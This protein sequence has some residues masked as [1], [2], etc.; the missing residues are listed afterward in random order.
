MELGEP[1]AVGLLDDHDRR[2]RNVDADLD[3][4]RGDQHVELAR[5]EARHH[6]APLGRTHAA[7]HA[8]DPEVAQLGAPQALGLGLG[9]AGERRLRLLDER[10][11]DVGL[12]AVGEVRAQPRVRLARAVLGH[13]SA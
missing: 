3:H 9:G 2:V 12:P 1:E 8:A 7:V 4:G 6:V 13:P 11:D 10:A 5:L